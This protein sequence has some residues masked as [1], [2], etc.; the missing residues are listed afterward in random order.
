MKL[1]GK[2]AFS[3]SMNPNVLTGSGRCPW[4]RRPRLF[5]AD[6]A[7]SAA[8]SLPPADAATPPARSRSAPRP[9]SRADSRG[10]VGLPHPLPQQLIGDPQLHRHRPLRL[11]RR[12]PQLH[13]MRP[14]PRRILRPSRH[15]HILHRA[16]APS[17]CPPNR[18][19]STGTDP[20][21]GCRNLTRQSLRSGHGKRLPLRIEHHMP[22]RHRDF[23]A[24]CPGTS[25][26]TRGRTPLAGSIDARLCRRSGSPALSASTCPSSTT[27]FRR[28]GGCP[29]DLVTCGSVSWWPAL[30]TVRPAA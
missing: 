15:R 1:T 24:L 10:G 29:V 21:P 18:V 28:P 11:P 22:A 25:M 26:T 30:A 14:E 17:G 6:P 3:A 20:S 4:R 19:S 12:P 27:V 16:D 9:V 5:S 13:R 23:E 7:P 2:F 8:S